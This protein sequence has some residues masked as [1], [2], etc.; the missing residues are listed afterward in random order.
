LHT[1]FLYLLVFAFIVYYLP[2]FDIVYYFP[3][4]ATVCHNWQ[5]TPRVG[6]AWQ[7]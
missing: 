5:D 2:L 3:L 1:V 7:Q 4:F 6:H